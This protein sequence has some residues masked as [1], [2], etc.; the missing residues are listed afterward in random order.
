M[1]DLAAP[2]VEEQDFAVVLA[3]LTADLCEERRETVIVVLRPAVER[4]V[5]TLRTLD[6]HSQEH[7]RHVLA[8]RQSIGRVHIK[9]CRGILERTSTG[10]E[11]LLDELIEGCVPR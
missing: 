6:P 8:Q 7:L 10:A 3:L 2:R 11:K 9:V 4:V 5:V 1:V